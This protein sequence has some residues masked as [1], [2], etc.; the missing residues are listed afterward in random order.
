MNVSTTSLAKVSEY[1]SST[2]RCSVPRVTLLRP[3]I[4]SSAALCTGSHPTSGEPA[5]FP[6]GSDETKYNELPTYPW[7]PS[8]KDFQNELHPASQAVVFDGCPDDPYKPSSTPIYQTSTY[9]QPSSS[10]FGA[11]DYTRSGNPTRT[12][13]EKHGAPAAAGCS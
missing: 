7:R 12:A 3:R 5:R 11:Y 8:F 2:M 9:A 6:H 13:L 4:Q 10:E 1:E